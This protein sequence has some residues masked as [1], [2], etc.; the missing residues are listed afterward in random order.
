MTGRRLSVI[1]VL[2][3]C[4]TLRQAY[5]AADTD[6]TRL[7][8]EADLQHTNLT[9]SSIRFEQQN[10]FD[11]NEPGTF[12]L[13]R[14][15][16][17]SHVISKQITIDNDLLFTP[18]SPLVLAELA[19][20]ERILRSRRYIRDAEVAVSRYCPETNTV[21]VLV[22]TWDNWSLLPK[23]DFS[24]EG[25]AT[26]YSIGVAEDN[27]L[28][29]G[30]QLQLDYA[31]DAERTGYLFS[32]A[33]PN[34]LGSRW[35]ALTRY[36]NNSDGESYQFNIQRPFYRLS[37]PW[38][39]S[40]DVSKDKQ[41][42]NDYV[43][44]EKVN[45]YDRTQHGFSS[46]FGWR[47]AG[48]SKQIHRFNSGITLEDVSFAANADTLFTLPDERNLSRVWVEYQLLEDQYRKLYNIN[49]FNRVEDINLGWQAY[50]RLG[51]L[52]KGLGADASGWQVDAAIEK[53]WALQSDIWLLASFRY[54]G[55]KMADL[56][57][58]LISTHWQMVY[59]LTRQ[60]S[61]VGILDLQRGKDLFADEALYL[62]GD[63][64]LRAFPLF[65]Q[66]GDNR[67]V[68]TT[69]YRYYTDWN[70]L[71]IFDVGFAG[72]ADAGRSWGADQ[73]GEN[74]IDDSILYGVGVGIRL[75]S[76][77]SSR[78]TMVHIDLTRPVTDNP[79]LG[80]WQWRITA[81]RRF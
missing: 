41:Q 45:Q 4:F 14:F 52:Q 6:C 24:S 76:T 49:Q 16:N 30:N 73:R 55:L 31:K 34:I 42:I 74:D 51:Q 21:E 56:N 28:G 2:L 15:A 35:Q 32:F 20:T 8:D 39:V 66:R 81:K 63:T 10:V 46:F 47:L 17:Y 60:S 50:L 58:Q 27:L 70:I 54:H 25:G 59:Q 69:E 22:K 19:E 37:S 68:A 5:A 48:D 3:A 43:L 65:Y 78:G 64:G 71:Q 18:E 9:I 11:L 44:G 33:S 77:H 1:V 29:T 79:E 61:L 36:A 7:F 62:G 72:F 57:Q 80:N 53:A 12:W 67:M 38:A 75:L 26:E 23:I 40:V 13:H